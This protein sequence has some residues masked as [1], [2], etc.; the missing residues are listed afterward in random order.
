MSKKLYPDVGFNKD[1]K[2]VLIGILKK[3]LELVRSEYICE[4]LDVGVLAAHL[5]DFCC[6]LDNTNEDD[7]TGFFGGFDGNTSWPA[8]CEKLQETSDLEWHVML[9]DHLSTPAWPKPEKQ[10]QEQENKTEPTISIDART[11]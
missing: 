4:P 8:L 2:M 9:S 1:A 11:A 3:A 6:F 7:S 10:E 5:R